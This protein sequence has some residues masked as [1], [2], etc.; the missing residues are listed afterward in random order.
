MVAIGESLGYLPEQRTHRPRSLL[1]RGG[2]SALARTPRLG[3][4]EGRPRRLACVPAAGTGPLARVTSASCPRRLARIVETLGGLPGAAQLT[5]PTPSLVS[6]E[7]AVRIRGKSAILTYLYMYV[8]FD[9]VLCMIG[10]H[11]L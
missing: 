6:V 3:P 10:V 1:S 4:A 9:R 11:I 8:C 2:K 7:R 5:R